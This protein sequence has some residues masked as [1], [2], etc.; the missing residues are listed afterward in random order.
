MNGKYNAASVAHYIVNKCI[1]DNCP[2]SNL[3]LQKILFLCQCDYFKNKDTM[4]ISDDFEAWQ[5]GPVV[6]DVYREYS[7]WGG[8]RINSQYDGKIEICEE[9]A[10]LIDPVIESKRRLYP[11]DLVEITH[12]DDSPWAITYGNGEGNGRIIQKE[13]IYNECHS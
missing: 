2:I 9:D 1:S 3:Q 5:Y 11:W 8:M 6:P 12:R 4:L 7:L 10:R 13:L